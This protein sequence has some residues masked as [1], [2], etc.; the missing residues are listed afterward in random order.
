MC[1]L[2][3]RAPRLRIAW[4][5]GRLWETQLYVAPQPHSRGSDL[6]YLSAKN[7]MSL[8]AVAPRAVAFGHF[9]PAPWV[10]HTP[11]AGEVLRQSQGLAGRCHWFL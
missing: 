4:M 3:L 9:Q 11:A 1:R 2:P 7:Y 8:V 6:A 5:H 10:E